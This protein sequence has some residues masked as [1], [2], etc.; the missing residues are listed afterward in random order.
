VGHEPLETLRT[1]LSHRYRVDREVGRGGMATVYLAQDLKHDRPVAIKVLHPELAAALGR[2]RFLREIQIAAKLQHP[3]ILSLYDSGDASGL[4]YYVMPFVQGESLQDRIAREK[5]L[6]LDEALRI[7]RE[8]ASALAYAHEHGVIHR[9]IKPGNILL[10]NGFALV[11]DFGLARAITRAK[12]SNVITHSGITIG[13]PS[14]MSPEQAGGETE[15]DG[16]SDVYALACVLYE[17]LAG[18]PPFSASTPAALLARHAAA[19]VPPIRVVRPA[20]P[21]WLDR[22]LRRGLEKL[23]AD[24]F[25]TAATFAKALEEP[26]IRRSRGLATLALAL[27]V[28]AALAIALRSVPHRKGGASELAGLD[29]RR[30]AVLYFDDH[31]ADRSLGYLADG[32][33]ESLIH[34]L[35]SVSAIQVISRNGVKPFRDAPV[36]IDSVATALRVGSLVEGSVQRSNDRLRVTVQ[37]IDART[38]AH[39]ESTTLERQMGELFKL[40]DDLANEVARLLR[41]RIGLEIR[42]RE[43][44]AGTA[45][46]E[47]RDLTF[48]ADKLRDDAEAATAGPDPHALTKVIAL[49]YSADS[50]L[51]RAELADRHWIDPVIARGWVALEAGLRQSGERRVQAFTR[52]M[53]LAIRAAARQPPHP[54]ALELRGTVLYYRAVRIPVDDSEFDKLL[55]DAETALE[56]A[57]SLDS[58]LATAW[59]MLSMVRIARG[60]VVLAEQ[61]ART[62]LA[63][64][65]YLKDAPDILLSLYG[66]TLMTDNV[67]ASWQ[68]CGRGAQ[69]YPSD[70]RFIECQLTLLAEDGTRSPDPRRAWSLVA[71]G[72]RL[73][74]PA[75]AAAAGRSFLPFY[76][77]MLAAVVSARAGDKDS[78]RSVAAR[79]RAL[80]AGDRELSLDLRYED[81][82]LHLVL[83]EKSEALRL[84]SQ[85]LTARPSLGHLVSQ[86]PRWRSL[87]ADPRFTELLRG[88]RQ[89]GNPVR[90]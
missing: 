9:D 38:N 17:L 55:G 70:P 41:R 85:Y 50:L 64:D 10:A 4:L 87:Q 61:N 52:A 63:M 65:A 66:A 73:D 90:P 16:R 19:P 58:T 28:V 78:A 46:A 75:H 43:T 26:P 13:T 51:A 37:L 6:P 72:N 40:E 88:A 32:L 68:W 22:A 76:R 71:E 57:V 74:P 20:V 54:A 12:D 53:D 44:I 48:R 89:P 2:E 7:V 25:P 21:A 14:Y 77:E 86:H 56:R 8:V 84:L 80:A 79:A 29:P 34:E 18:D 42:V 33:T 30:I 1:V 62:A 15:L 83:G 3:H 47:A 82:Y 5:Q 24:R 11:A 23:P 81:A 27:L 45:S 31:S 49:L 35:S 36:P 69:D 59:G 60:E 39:L 67:M